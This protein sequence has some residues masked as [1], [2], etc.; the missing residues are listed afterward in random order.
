MKSN[1]FK[2]PNTSSILMLILVG[3]LAG[4][5]VANFASTEFS[6]SNLTGNIE[7]AG[8]KWATLF[9]VAFCG[10]DFAGLA[11]LF[12]PQKG[13]DEPIEVMLLG[14][15][16][17]LAAMMNALLTWWGVTQAMLAQGVPG[18]EI[19]THQELIVWF[20]RLAAGL[21]FLIRILLIGSLTVAIEGM[22]HHKPA[23][24][25][26]EKPEEAR[27]PLPNPQA[28]FTSRF[29]QKGKG[30]DPLFGKPQ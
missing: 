9:A 24:A 30:H 22:S 29:N 1:K 23:F 16:W 7:F 17:I 13:K 5:E 14:G 6:L 3:S 11:R 26:K 8:I 21:I 18:N 19:L 15:A 10:A 12:T 25:P 4:F 2:S 28:S 27:I 20:P